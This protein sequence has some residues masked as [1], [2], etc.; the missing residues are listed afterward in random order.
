MVSRGHCHPLLELIG[1]QPPSYI[2]CFLLVAPFSNAIGHHVI[3][4]LTRSVLLPFGPPAIIDS[5]QIKNQSTNFTSQTVQSWAL[6]HRILC[7]F[8]LVYLPQ[9]VGF[10][11]RHNGS[12][13]DTFL[14]LWSSRWSPK[15]AEVLPQAVGLL[16][17]LVLSSPTPT[18][19]LVV[20]SKD[21]PFNPDCKPP[22]L[23]H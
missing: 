12:L 21:S 22:L 10:T 8:Y 13:K 23:W 14:K 20:F 19:Q 16:N 5:N 3:F 18:H 7:N 6:E 9:A 11:E 4:L 1:V 15:W 2:S 17:S